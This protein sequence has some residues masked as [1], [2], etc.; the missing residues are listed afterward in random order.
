MMWV[1]VGLVL[2]FL[3]FDSNL[4]LEKPPP[5]I[6]EILKKG[7]LDKVLRL[8][9]LNGTVSTQAFRNGKR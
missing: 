9:R 7:C 3:P 1:Y 6:M 5:A 2:P 4:G 8:Q